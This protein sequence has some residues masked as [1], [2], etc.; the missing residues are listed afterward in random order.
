[1]HLLGGGITVKA[2]RAMWRLPVDMGSSDKRT[3]GANH[4]NGCDS[5]VADMPRSNVYAASFHFPPA[6]GLVRGRSSSWTTYQI[7]LQEIPL[8]PSPSYVNREDDM[9]LPEGP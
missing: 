6:R 3:Q 1:M 4:A 5:R 9:S 7:F 2:G 8:L